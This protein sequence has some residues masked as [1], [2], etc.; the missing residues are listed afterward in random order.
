M[1]RKTT[2]AVAAVLIGISGLSL[3]LLAGPQPPAIDRAPVDER[4]ASGDPR[5]D[6]SPALTPEQKR[7]EQITEKMRLNLVRLPNYTCTETIER[8][9]KAPDGVTVLEDTLRLEVG[10]ID[11]QEIFAWPGS[12]EFLDT[13][14]KNLIGSGT[15]GNGAFGLYAEMLFYGGG[16]EF[17]PQG[18]V[19]LNGEQVL[20]YN[21]D[22]PRNESRYRMAVNGT[23]DIVGFKG[24]IYVDPE[25]LDLRRIEIMAQ[26]IPP[27]LRLLAASDRV[28]YQRVEIGPES[29]LLP[30]GNLLTMVTPSAQNQNRVRFTNCHK[31]QGQSV[32]SFEDPVDL[33]AAEEKVIKEVTIPSDTELHIVVNTQI[34]MEETAVGD[35]VTGTLRDRVK[36]DGEELIPK[37]ATVSGRVIRL[38]RLQ[39]GYA[40]GILLTDIHWDGGHAHMDAYLDRLPAPDLPF[41]ATD[42]MMLATVEPDPPRPGARKQKAIMLPRKGPTSVKNI[43]TYWRTY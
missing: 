34:E 12:S 5:P 19:D 10:L 23:R 29:F 6:V 3:S 37:G 25:T 16:P 28:D 38:D 24:L 43:L 17:V 39:R 1:S 36:V 27:V 8:T 9:R 22:V 42:P 26:E 11:G 21:F 30:S 31:F 15:Y 2:C 33:L 14:L 40:V 7:I 4:A 41:P 13:E 35:A 32:I 20:K 18:S